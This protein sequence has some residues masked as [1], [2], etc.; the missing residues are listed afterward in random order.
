[1]RIRA[2][3]VADVPAVLAL[4]AV[5]A[6][7]DA[8]PVDT[9]AAVE[10]LIARDPEALILAVEGDAIVGSVIAGWD[11][12]RYHLYRLAVHPSV[13]RRGIGHELV[14][15]AEARFAAAGATRVDAMVLEGNELGQQLWVREGYVPQPEWRRWVK[16]AD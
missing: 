9:S 16:N 2:A 1:M 11:G 10:T 6:E 5:A 8:R 3:T 7:N 4:W 13:R 12:W 15:C 14:V